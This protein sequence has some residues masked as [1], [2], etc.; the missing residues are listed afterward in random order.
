[1]LV[2][3][4]ISEGVLWPGRPRESP[5]Q[6]CEG[7]YALASSRLTNTAHPACPSPALAALGCTQSG[8]RVEPPSDFPPCHQEGRLSRNGDP[9]PHAAAR[10]CAC[11]FTPAPSPAATQVGPD[12]EGGGRHGRRESSFS[13]A[14]RTPGAAQARGSGRRDCPLLTPRRAGPE[15]AGSRDSGPGVQPRGL[16][17]S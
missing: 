7:E 2:R 10:E 6:A 1:M 15:R 12:C 11:P 17:A 13:P 5:A 9:E 3:E 4:A 14:T 8:A 16:R